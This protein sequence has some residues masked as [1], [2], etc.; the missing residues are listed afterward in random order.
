MTSFLGYKIREPSVRCEGLYELTVRAMALEVVGLMAG[1]TV[2]D[3]TEQT[4]IKI[5]GP[6]YADLPKGLSGPM[7]V[8][9]V[10]LP[11]KAYYRMDAVLD[12][13]SNLEWP[14]HEVV[15]PAGL[16]PNQ[17]GLFGWVGEE[18]HKTFVPISLREPTN[19]EELTVDLNLYIRV[20]SD[21][22]RIFWRVRKD[23]TEFEWLP[24]TDGRRVRAGQTVT[25][26]LP[27]GPVEVIGVDVTAKPTGSD[28]WTSL[29]FDVLRAA[30]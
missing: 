8:R 1:P 3:F 17:I 20:S 26:K 16:K 15:K 27:P 28:N 10:A 18:N 9:A 6:G 25:L 23:D 24:A 14:V 7:R 4:V 2:P 12:E 19:T 13:S 30:P 22:D 29:R 5:F 11:L 21:A